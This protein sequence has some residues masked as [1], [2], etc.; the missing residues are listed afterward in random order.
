MHPKEFRKTKN[1]TGH[2]TNLSLENCELHVGINFSNNKEINSILANLKNDCYVI[3]PSIKSIKLNETSVASKEEKN[4]VF[5]LIDATWACSRSM[6]LKSPNLD[7]LKK[8]SFI[9]T[10]VSDFTFKTQPKEYCLSTMESTL[11]VLEL[12]TQNKDEMLTKKE[13]T[14]FLLPFEKMVEYQVKCIDDAIVKESN[15]Q[16][17]SFELSI[18]TV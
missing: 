3:Y 5:F 14:S 1:G 6:L 7:T 4:T 2:F 8:V 10:K 17:D 18:N 9:H 15:I 13:L 16:H 12:L 11:C